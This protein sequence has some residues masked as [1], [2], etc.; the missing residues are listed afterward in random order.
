MKYDLQK[1]MNA[2]AM[3]GTGNSSILDLRNVVNMSLQFIVTGASSPTG[4]CIIT[5]SDDCKVTDDGTISGGNFAVDAAAPAPP[6]ITA[7][8][9]K[10]WN[11]TNVGHLFARVEYTTGT[12]SGTLNVN[13]V[14]KGV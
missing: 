5:F 10:M 3:A 4:T 8:G 13:G 12:G 6:V 1:I 11:Y 2:F 14:T 9:T 7:N